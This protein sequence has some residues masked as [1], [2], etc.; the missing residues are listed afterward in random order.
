MF[1]D[2]FEMPDVL[3]PSEE[4]LDQ[5]PEEHKKLLTDIEPTEL[6]TKTF[7]IFRELPTLSE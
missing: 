4:L 5:L 1:K 3:I 7:D 2:Y 6:L